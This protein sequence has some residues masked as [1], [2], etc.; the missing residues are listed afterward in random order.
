MEQ[1]LLLFVIFLLVMWATRKCD[2]PPPVNQI[3]RL[4]II[5]GVPQPKKH[6]DKLRKN[7]IRS[8][9]IRIQ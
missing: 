5:V 4:A 2:C 3:D 8:K 7:T 6:Y 9:G 1:L